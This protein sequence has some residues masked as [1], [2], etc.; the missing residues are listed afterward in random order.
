[1]LRGIVYVTRNIMK[2]KYWGKF[3]QT[4]DQDLDCVIGEKLLEDIHQELI[5][6]PELGNV[7]ELGC[8]TGYFYPVNSSKKH[9]NHG[10]GSIGKSFRKSKRTYGR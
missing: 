5:H 3:A 10:Y 6:L 2:E 1:M 8:G 9:E 4:Y 7:L